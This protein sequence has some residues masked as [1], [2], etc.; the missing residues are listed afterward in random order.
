MTGK[1]AQSFT[2]RIWMA[3]NYANAEEVC[4]S[5]CEQGMCV[6]ICPMNYIYTGGEESGFCVTL[7]NYPRF[8]KEPVKLKEIAFDLA[9]LLMDRLH[10]QSFSIEHPDETLF[11]SKRPEDLERPKKV[12]RDHPT[13]AGL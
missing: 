3:G 6:S 13:G 2:I 7:I 1:A 8:P 9:M 11:F 4:R 12:Y 5:F 10:Q